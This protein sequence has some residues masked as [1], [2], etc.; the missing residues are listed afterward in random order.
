MGAFI[1]YHGCTKFTQN[2]SGYSSHLSNRT[3]YTDMSPRQLLMGVDMMIEQFI[4]KFRRQMCFGNR[5]AD[6]VGESLPER[7]GGG[8]HAGG[9]AVFGMAGR[10]AAPLSKMF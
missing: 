3:T 9:Q 1:R 10:D 7:P 4:T 8:L 5:K 6:A 2:L